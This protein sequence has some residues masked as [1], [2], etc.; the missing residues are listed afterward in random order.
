MKT[1]T[2]AS[3]LFTAW[4]GNLKFRTNEWMRQLKFQDA[5][6][7]FVPFIQKRKWQIWTIVYILL[8]TNIQAQA[9]GPLTVST[10]P[11]CSSH[12]CSPT[13][14]CNCS[15]GVIVTGGIPPYMINVFGATGIVGQGACITGLCP[16]TYTFEVRDQGTLNPVIHQVTVG[17]S[18]CKLLCRDTVFCFNVPD[19]MIVLPPPAFADTSGGAGTGPGGCAYDSIYSNAPGVYPVGTT[20]VKW[21]VHLPDGSIDSCSQNVIRNPPSVYNIS[22][23]TS[24]PIVG[25]VINICNGQSI[26]FNDFST[27]I[28]GLLWNFGNGYYSS[29]SNHAEPASHYP[30]GTYFDTLTVFDDCGTPHDTAF[31][32]V[33]DSA[34]GPDIT[35]ISV[36]CPGDTVTYHT[37]VNCTNYV[38]SVIGGV[39][40]PVPSPTSD[41]CTV[42]WGAGPHGTI[43][44]SVSGCTP[45]TTCSVAT[46]KTVDIV[47]TTL[48]IAGDTV[49]CAG[50]TATYCIECI[51]GNEHSWEMLPANAGTITG[52]NTCCVTIHFNP[53]FFGTVSLT[54]NYQNVLTGTGCNLPS[55]CIHDPGC[56]GSGVINITVKP[57][58][59]INGPAKVCPG[60]TSSP[61]AGMNLTN[62]TAE[63]LTSWKLVTPSAS[64]LFFAS[65][66]LLNSYTWNAGPG[67]YQL[68]AYAPPGIYCNDSA[69]VTVE[70]VDVQIPNAITGPDTVCANTPFFYSTLPN[71]TG[72]TYTW[73]V[74]GGTL[75]P[76][77]NGSSVAISWNPGGGTVSVYQTLTA[78]PGCVSSSSATFTVNTWPAFPLPT[79]TSSQPI[80]C[81]KST[82]TYSIPPALIS[83]GTYTWSVVPSTAGNIMTAN[84]TNTIT[85]KWVDA[86]ITPIYVKLKINRCYEDSVMLPINLL[87]LPPV[88]S[89]S[90]TPAD[91]CV[92]VP[93]LFSTT[94][95]G[96]FW[97]WNFGDLAT[98]TTQ[99]PTHAY[100]NGGDFTVQLYVTNA[101]GCS[102]TAYTQIHIDTLPAVPTIVGNPSVCLN[103]TENY[104]FSE[105]LFMGAAYTWSLS[106]P[107]KGNIV[108]SGQNF[109]NVKWTIPGVDT[110]KLHVQ[111]ICLDTTIRFV[112][113]VHALPIAGISLPS[114]SCVGT[115]LTF[116]GS[117]GVTYSWSF[118]GG[119]PSTSI[120]PSPTVTYGSA[121][122]YAVSLSVVDVNGCTASSN[123]TLA[124]HGLP[125]AIITGPAR[126]CSFPATVTLSAVNLA[127]YSFAWTP[128]GSTFTITPTINTQTAFSCVVTNVFG[129]TQTSNTLILDTTSCPSVVPPGCT[130]TD[131]INFVESPPVCLT[132]SYTKTGNASLIGWD[133]GDGG[134]AGPVS[135]VSHTY[136]FPGIYQIT[137]Y[138][139]ATGIDALGN[140][141]IDTI[142][143]IRNIVIPFDVH[144][145]FSY[146]CNGS[147]VM[148]AVFANTSLYLGNASSYNWTW[149]DNTTATTIST[150][151]FPAPITL[152]PGVHVISVTAFDPVTGATCTETKT[153]TVP[154]PI[155]AAFNVSTPICQGTAALFTDISFNLANESTRLFNNGNGATSNAS[156]ASLIYANSGP[157]VATLTVSDIYGCNSTASQNVSVLPA[158][159]GSITVGVGSCDSVQLTASGSGPYTWQVINPPPFP[160]N[161]VYVH[162]S[163]FY[164]VTGVGA[165]GCPYT[166]GPVQVTVKR[167]PTATI[168]G[169]TV[170]CQGEKLDL[171]TTSAGTS[172]VWQQLVPFAGVVGTNAPNLNITANTP[173][174]ITYSV[175]VTSA[176]GCSS[177]ASITITVDPVPTSAYIDSSSSLTFCEGDSVLLTVV[178]PGASYLW[179]KSPTPALTSPADSNDSLWVSV[180]GTYSVIVQTINGCAYPAIA[181]VN[182]TVNP[183]PVANITGDTVMCVGD[184]LLLQTT[185]VGGG[186]Y[187]WVGPIATGS[188]NPFVVPN[189]QLGDGGLYTVTVTNSYGCTQTDA[190]T[191]VVN[192]APVTPFITSN[193]GGV[194]CEGALVTFTAAPAPVFPVVYTWSTG[195]NGVSITAAMAGNYFVVATN[196]FGCSSTSNILTIHPLPDLSCVPSGCYEFCNECDSVTIPGPVGF[197]SYM[198]QQLVGNV[199][200]NY[201]NNQ[202][203]T[204]LPPGGMYRLLAANMWGC[205]DSS[206]TLKINFRDC[207]TPIVT[208]IAC[209]DT[210]CQDFSDNLLH[211]FTP[212]AIAP[213]VLVGLNNVGGQYPG[214]VFV[215]ATDLAGPSGVQTD[216][217]YLGKW[218]CGKFSYDFKIFDDGQAGSPAIAPRFRIFNSVL[219]KGFLFT[220]SFTMTELSGWKKIVACGG[221]DSL[222]QNTSQGTW[223]PIAPAVLSDWQAVASN[224]TDVVIATQVTS[225]GEV[226]GIDNVCYTPQQF[227]I[228]CKKTKVCGGYIVSAEISDTSAC[229]TFHYEWSNGS[230][231]PFL[232]LPPPG[233]YCVKISNCCGCIDSCCITV[234]PDS[235][236]IHVTDTVY[237]INC[238]SLYGGIALRVTGGYPP[239]NYQW[240]NGNTTE[241]QFNLPAGIYNIIIT[242]STGCG[243]IVHDT[244][245]VQG[246]CNCN[247]NP[248]PPL[249][250]IT[251]ISVVADSC[252]QSGC[253]NLAFTGCCLRYAYSYHSL[254]SATMVDSMSWTKDSTIFCH[255]RAGYYTIYVSDP[256]GN[257]VSQSVFVPSVSPPLMTFVTYANCGSQ[258]CVGAEGGCG[259]YSYVWSDGSTSN[260]LHNP[261]PCVDLTVTITDAYGCSQT[262]VVSPP[263]VDFTNVVNP[264]C[265]ASNGSLCA[266]VCFGPQPYTYLWSTGDTGLCISNVPAG[267]Y[268][269]TITNA[270]GQTT[271]CCYTLTNGTAGVPSVHFEFNNCGSIVNAIIDSTGCGGF[272]YYWNNGIPGLTFE[273]VHPCDSLTFTI[274]TCDGALH[275]F[276]FTVPGIF[277]SIQP[278]DCITGLGTIC[279]QTECFRCAPYT[280]TWTPAIAGN[281]T[282]TNCIQ[283]PSGIYNLCITNSCGDVICCSYYL[284]PLDSSHIIVVTDTVYN[285]DCDHAGGGIDINPTGGY[286]PYTY[287]WSTGAT[288]Q[289]VT[290]LAEGVYSVIVTDS[291]GCNTIVHDTVV[292]TTTC[293][294]ATN[295]PTITILGV[296]PD[297]CTSNGCIHATFT[298]CCLLYSYSYFNP[299]NPALSYS[300][301]QT[302]DS[303]IFCNLAAGTYTIYIMDACGNMVQQ[304]VVVPS[305]NPPLSV[306]IEY[307]LCGRYVC[308][309][310]TGG[311]A[312][313]T[314]SWIGGG[315]GPCMFGLPPCTMTQ[316]VVTDAKGCSITIDVV[317]PGATFTNIVEPSCCLANGSICVNACFGP[318]PYT[319]SWNN[320]MSGACISGLAAGTYCVTITN[321][322]GQQFECCYDLIGVPVTPPTVHFVFDN[323]G[324]SVHAVLGEFVCEN[325]TGHWEDGVAGPVHGNLTHCDSLTY[326]L[327][328]CD[329][330]EYH[331]GFRVPHLTASILP[332]DCITGLG[333]ICVE[334]DCFRCAPYTYSW[335]PAIA[336]NPSDTNC[337]N[338]PSGIYNLC[339]TNACGDVICC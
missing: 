76:P 32:V 229:N 150:T 192:P 194:L 1:T 119:T 242:D 158:G 271:T 258:V 144:F 6:M 181:P 329:G 267:V 245:T 209:V 113:T 300:V 247:S 176:N 162:T 298:G 283:V 30:P 45:A 223:T 89:I 56:G 134:T 48:P 10:D 159:T 90:Y 145:D 171:K 125:L 264:T 338:V 233:T 320:G 3:N 44:L 334:T 325:F 72:V 215:Q 179:S 103:A 43:S 57:I 95:A 278:V 188:S 294:C 322:D 117:G 115:P 241:S 80:V 17:G 326:T 4:F 236:I 339:I 199:W 51:P 25:G 310:A 318:Q 161:P 301:P 5:G 14:P 129:C 47:P 137:V 104:S 11:N 240:S 53:N 248:P 282:D 218:C 319:Y 122:N 46:I 67:V 111:S 195:Q 85:I 212:Y 2:P 86:S 170:Y 59:G 323:C 189:M 200:V 174:T 58:F 208:N 152:T 274:V 276:G 13:I 293:D 315:T 127:G 217:T 204:I 225:S 107:V 186:T 102:D 73:N 41:S 19:S 29:N 121:G 82:V 177:S 148:Q 40:S 246:D 311:C 136:A 292:V 108:S 262:I 265:C 205:A 336:G 71:M 302:R 251:V 78:A 316:V 98:S 259:P 88:P 331:F 100:T 222:P 231:E 183:K 304:N 109:L 263:H 99:N 114:P 135:P 64:P 227:S 169:K 16:G 252:N 112:V 105:P 273:G 74:T 18:C 8:S 182:V 163:G 257:I 62:N 299:C 34:S 155:V 151:A 9:G 268:C 255:L 190:I 138:G 167:S 106:A 156:P 173:G 81:L 296:D 305:A 295:P 139:S 230:H 35:C 285:I 101:N 314:Y 91:P 140:I 187:S 87:A 207:C 153:L 312:P 39:F 154:S 28:T 269:L 70:V 66:A 335:S 198:W 261:Q 228:S 250:T 69:I 201:S 96:P 253:I 284:P 290:G 287:Q 21:Y 249:P 328:S 54:V 132:Q 146:Q 141:C 49:L 20:V 226:V 175:T 26:T 65:S 330:T 191:V 130:T 37:N 42:V 244:V 266:S 203:L 202:N 116:S 297:V 133:F 15:A 142:Y 23:T 332:V 143:K 184:Q 280:Y 309:N 12:C 75:I 178:P 238:D 224:V 55:N 126:I 308:A 237:H 239:Y 270:N 254:C 206:D 22:F 303:S 168:S 61:F 333:S 306:S 110:V 63:P 147:N 196:Q 165:N 172:F 38:W 324:E 84:G 120:L 123:T 232:E 166:A 277:G 79:I 197:A 131:T 36:V 164:S 94:S 321:R 289:D 260:C 275:H 243:T 256:C 27:G 83:N 160:T 124:V 24:P 118:G 317:V 33:V 286:P 220:A 307:G 185:P 291:I 327:V 93:V 279:V 214:D 211:N 221:L 219:N 50:A 234:P 180:T 7:S 31:K 157:F 68:T 337:I 193:P 216:T 235:N 272:T 97:N 213:N 77:I 52:T 60:V 149:Y 288:T 92:N 128:S 281:P 210:T 313:Y